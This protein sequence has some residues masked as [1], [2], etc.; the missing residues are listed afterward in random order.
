MATQTG[1]TPRARHDPHSS[2]SREVET[3]ARREAGP[4]VP[5][6]KDSVVLKKTPAMK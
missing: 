3:P 5:V 6:V 4:V 2:H 1:L